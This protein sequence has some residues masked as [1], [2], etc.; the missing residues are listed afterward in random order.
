MNEEMNKPEVSSGASRI[1][2]H[3]HHMTLPVMVVAVGVVLLLSAL[4]LLTGRALSVAFAILVIVAG[5]LIAVKR[6]CNCYTRTDNG[7]K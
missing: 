2:R 3:F 5:V 4:D 6:Q 1:C 7:Q